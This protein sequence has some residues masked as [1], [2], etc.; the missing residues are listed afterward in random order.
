[1]L[2][3]STAAVLIFI[4]NRYYLGSGFGKGHQKLSQKMDPSQ[5]V[6]NKS[7]ETASV[8]RLPASMYPQTPPSCP[9]QS[10][11][12]LDQVPPEDVCAFVMTCESGGRAPVI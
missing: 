7:Y 8:D 2:I 1:M 12:D 3:T 4:L 11:Q 6:R 5:Y 9:L 10:C